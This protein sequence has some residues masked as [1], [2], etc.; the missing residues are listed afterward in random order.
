MM[1]KKNII[2]I[3][4]VLLIIAIF[5]I[6]MYLSQ[7][8]LFEI[9]SCLDNGGRWDYEDKSCVIRYTTKRAMNTTNTNKLNFRC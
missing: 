2:I 3:F 5:I 8:N 9:D 6:G 7:T 4:S 1:V